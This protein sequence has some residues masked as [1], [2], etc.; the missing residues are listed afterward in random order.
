MQPMRSVK[1]QPALHMF[2][3]EYG[4]STLS[5]KGS[6]EFDPSFV[7]TKLGSRVNRVIVAGLLERIEGRDVANGSVIYQGQLR[8][9]S[10]INY[11]SVGDY[12][13]DSVKEMTIQLSA[14]LESGEPI[15]LLMVAKTRLYQTE[16]GAIY[17]SLRPEEMCIIDAQRYASWLANTSES[18]MN[19]MSRYVA[20][21]DFEANMESLSKSEMS[22]NQ[23]L[24]L[25]ASRNH[26]GDIDLEHYRLN[27][28]QALD[29]AEGKLD[30]ATKPAPQKLIVEED[31][32]EDQ[33]GDDKADLEAAI[34]DIITK[35]D[36][37]DGVEFETILVNAEA[38]GF[39]R[40]IAEEKLE[41]L[42]DDGTV[43]EPAF[44]WF[45]LV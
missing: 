45:R 30:A 18:M 2:A 37:G 14:R 31:D 24:G 9:P 4:E 15:L 13:S 5:E 23:I 10:G 7:V 8:D 36:Q 17:T 25:I 16:E 19:R 29:I 6:G 40:S 26:Y 12:V 41:E 3:S 42:S 32:D 34:V 43:H 38:R 21:L 33:N 22:E 27:V 39:Q 35:L 28:M 44:G 1:R 11:F 20:S